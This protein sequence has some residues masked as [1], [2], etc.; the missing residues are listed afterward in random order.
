LRTKVLATRKQKRI[1]CALARRDGQVR[2]VQRP[3]TASLMAGMWELPQWADDPGASVHATHWRTFRHSI[4]V[5]DYTVHV[6]RQAG[7]NGTS[8]ARGKWIAIDKVPH[9]PIT[10]LTRKIL[11]ADGII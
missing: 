7:R 1:W 3:K 6:L 2:L 10:G 8:G 5:T 9:L 4:T 11:K